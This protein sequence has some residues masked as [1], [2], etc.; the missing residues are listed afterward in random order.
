LEFLGLFEREEQWIQAACIERNVQSV[1]IS[2]HQ[3]GIGDAIIDLSQLQ[4][5]LD[6]R[7][8]ALAKSTVLAWVARA[9]AAQR[10]GL[11]ANRVSFIMPHLRPPTDEHA[12]PWQT[13]LA[14]GRLME[15]L[16]ADQPDTIQYLGPLQIVQHG[17]GVQG[18]RERARMNLSLLF[19][20]TLSDCT[21]HDSQADV[22]ICSV[23]DGHDAARLLIADQLAGGPVVAW[24]PHRDRMV[25]TRRF[26]TELNDTA[27]NLRQEAIRSALTATHPITAE[28]FHVHD[29]AVSH[30][31]FIGHDE[32]GY[33]ER[34]QT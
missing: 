25:F 12:L 10:K 3:I 1:R 24:V 31:R 18:L 7:P 2:Q 14:E 11:Q 15:C 28:A 20:Y 30:M 16:V 23:G 13:P 17:L 5:A 6:H 4:R 8:E 32:H 22:W 33:L 9:I 19:P 21:P 34:A 27:W 29:G 26:A